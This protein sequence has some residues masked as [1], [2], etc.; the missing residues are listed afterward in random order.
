MTAGDQQRSVAEDRAWPVSQ[1]PPPVA[2]PSQVP[3]RTAS[4]FPT[5]RGTRPSI[6]ARVGT[7]SHVTRTCRQT[8]VEQSE[9]SAFVD[10]TISHLGGHRPEFR[11]RF[12]PVVEGLAAVAAGHQPRPHAYGDDGDERSCDGPGQGRVSAATPR[13]EADRGL[14]LPR[15]HQ[16]RELRWRPGWR[17]PELRS[18]SHSVDK[19]ASHGS[20]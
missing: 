19:A 20:P 7:P 1:R 6:S 11:G 12:A 9:A 5:Q 2:D 8:W 15:T 4:T 14:A 10:W 13:D 3:G 17:G 18:H 16:L